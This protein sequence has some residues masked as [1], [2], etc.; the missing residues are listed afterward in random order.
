MPWLGVVTGFFI[1][2]A[3][4]FS[5]NTTT[6]LPSLS[7]ELCKDQWYV[8][9][10]TC[11]NSISYLHVA[12]KVE[13]YHV[14]E[15]GYEYILPWWWLSLIGA[16]FVGMANSK[17]H[18]PWWIFIAMVF[19]FIVFTSY[20]FD[21]SFCPSFDGSFK[22]N[23]LLNST[24]FEVEI[25]ETYTHEDAAE[26]YTL[27]NCTIPDMQD[28]IMGVFGAALESSVC[29]CKIYPDCCSQFQNVSLTSL[30]SAYY[31]LMGINGTLPSGVTTVA[32]AGL[33]PELINF[34]LELQDSGNVNTDTKVLIENAFKTLSQLNN[35]F[36]GIS[37]A[38]AEKDLLGAITNVI[39][40]GN[41][42]ISCY[43]SKYPDCCGLRTENFSIPIFNDKNQKVGNYWYTA[44]LTVLEKWNCPSLCLAS[45]L[46]SRHDNLLFQPWMYWYNLLFLILVAIRFLLVCWLFIRVMDKLF[47][48]VVR[49]FCKTCCFDNPSRKAKLECFRN[50][51]VNPWFHPV[52]SRFMVSQ[53]MVLMTVLWFHIISWYIVMWIVDDVVGEQIPTPFM[54]YTYTYNFNFGKGFYKYA[55]AVYLGAA[56]LL[57]G[58]NT[59][60]FGVYWMLYVGYKMLKRDVGYVIQKSEGDSLYRM[61]MEHDDLSE[62]LCE[63]Q[64]DKKERI[65]ENK[66]AWGAG[67]KPT[68]GAGS[69]PI[70]QLNPFEDLEKYQLMAMNES[71]RPEQK[72]FSMYTKEGGYIVQQ[73][74]YFSKD[75]V[76]N[77]GVCSSL[78]S[79]FFP[80]QE[81]N[82]SS[83]TIYED[84]Q[85][86]NPFLAS[87]FPA[88]YIVFTLMGVTILLL[89]VVG[90][91]VILL[92]LVL[93]LALRKPVFPE[94]WPLTKSWLIEKVLK[95]FFFIYLVA[96]VAN[97]YL[98]PK[99]GEW[100]QRI[101]LYQG[102][103]MLDVVYLVTW[104][105][106]KAWTI[107]ATIIIVDIIVWGFGRM[108]IW[109][110]TLRPP[111]QLYD[112]KYASYVAVVRAAMI[113]HH[114]KKNP[115][116]LLQTTTIR[117]QKATPLLNIEN[118][119]SD[120]LGLTVINTHR[121]SSDEWQGNTKHLGTD[122]DKNLNRDTILSYMTIDSN[123]DTY[124]SSGTPDFW[125]NSKQPLLTKQGG[126][127]ARS[128]MELE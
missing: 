54:G 74:E 80:F 104:G 25:V 64:D 45:A 103:V 69:K 105:M 40:K 47:R 12:T 14:T 5:F 68:T 42:S 115:R 94:G 123:V 53:L 16:G 18:L 44:N 71:E 56:I 6:I 96:W 72:S 116:I 119:H 36:S 65:D 27:P 21:L 73:N 88:I 124:R 38:E 114:A 39:Q 83:R 7:V 30:V 22:Y 46:K 89:V 11:S 35:W 117:R 77:W 91:F 86:V 8:S 3:L 85:R 33:S 102:V 75:E 107:L 93:N 95:T 9:N 10:P 58:V 90:T 98:M 82:L 52:S 112:S 128:S 4:L 111:F 1:I 62:F 34:I 26:F 20:I 60:F 87:A 59:V 67:Y 15:F 31:C 19:E 79:V 113:A 23:P 106:L 92:F 97:R 125:Q 76:E 127:K 28:A 126:S 61:T 78:K 121:K 122:R 110:S 118:T 55:W 100:R 43:C 101:K 50:L 63:L 41:E 70:T 49:C 108:A 29:I 13:E 37:C 32:G 120:N 99:E 84:C 66:P 109:Q 57:L 17:F 2:H 51:K 48:N 81:R 24:D